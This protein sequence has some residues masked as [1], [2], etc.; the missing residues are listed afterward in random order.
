MNPLNSLVRLFQIASPVD[1]VINRVRYQFDRK[2]RP[3]GAQWTRAVMYRELGEIVAKL[4]PERL[5]ALE[6]SPGEFW[7][8]RGFKSY[9]GVRYPDF[10]V[11]SQV[12]PEKFDLIIAD[13]VFEH[14]HWPY[15][16]GKNVYQ[17]LKPGGHFIN[18]TPFLVRL[19]DDPVDCSR[20]TELGMKYLLAECG[21]ELSRIRT[22]A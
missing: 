9:R 14:L 13:Q 2:P 20:W 17:M 7:Q 8:G 5:D 18:T 6:I 11:C 10:D 1:Y 21:F 19:H 12:L 4:G 16:A 15:R 22:G 3:Q